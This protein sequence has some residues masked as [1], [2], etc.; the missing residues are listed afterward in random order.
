MAF[1]IDLRRRAVA[2]LTSASNSLQRTAPAFFIS[3][4]LASAAF[5]SNCRAV[6]SASILA[7]A[8]AAA[9][10]AFFSRLATAALP[11]AMSKVDPENRTVV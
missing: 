3:E 1:S 11:L 8:S 9:A 6:M 4:S 7:L 5:T 10:P 2:A